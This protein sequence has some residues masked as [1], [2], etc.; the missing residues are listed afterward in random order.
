MDINEEEISTAYTDL[1]G[2]F[3]C[4]LSSKNVYV[5]V[6][7]H[8]NASI[9]MAIFLKN[10]QADTITTA[11]QTIQ[12]TFSKAGVA[13]KIQMMHNEISAQFNVALTKNKAAYQLVPLDT[14]RRNLVERTIQSFK[15]HFKSGLASVDPNFLLSVQDRLIKQANI[16]LNLLR[17]ERSNPKLSAYTYM[18]GEFSFSATPLSPPRN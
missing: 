8:Y 9:V 10:R 17:S 4:K 16:T 7:Y 11:W 18:Y 14:H 12:D 2:R 15:N 1:T 3:P 5:M 6:A 13:P